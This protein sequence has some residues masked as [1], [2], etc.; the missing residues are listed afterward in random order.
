VG[1]SIGDRDLAVGNVN[2]GTV[3]ILK[4]NGAANFHE[5][6]SSPEITG[7][8]SAWV[9]GA[10][11]DLDGD[12]DLASADFDLDRVDLLRNNGAGN[13]TEP[14]SSP[15]AVGDRPFGIAIAD[16]DG[17]ADQDLATANSGS[18]NLTIL[19]NR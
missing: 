3:T 17:D 15:E 4:N 11:F 16:F 9:V 12:R 18:D 5:P 14:A 13:F 19:R 6:G 7:T 10:D 2:F 8:R 1:A